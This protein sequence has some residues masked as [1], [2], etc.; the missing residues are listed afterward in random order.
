MTDSIQ[1]LESII[2]NLVKKD[3]A[4]IIHAGHF[5]LLY[6]KVHDKIIPGI[7]PYMKQAGFEEQLC[8]EM[9]LF[10][11]LTWE[12]AVKLLAR[13]EAR[14]KNLLIIVNDW[15]YLKE[16]KERR[17]EFYKDC[18]ALPREFSKILEDEGLAESLL[19]TPA[20]NVRTGVY[21]SEKHMRKKFQ[22][23]VK[24]IGKEINLTEMNCDLEKTG[25]FCGN[26]NCAA[27][28]AQVIGEVAGA[29]NAH[30]HVFVN[31]YPLSCRAFVEEGSR[32]ATDIFQLKHTII[33][34]I[35][36]SNLGIKTIDDVVKGMVLSY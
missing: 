21:F 2:N 20:R 5:L 32:V 8:E 7:Y 1:K 28:I 34:N 15:Q 18:P 33:L 10:P 22:R 4:L 23:T 17:Y 9:G 14:K 13:I 3:S 6:D 25:V 36:V 12:L 27:E 24:K 30:A 31:F 19:L 29:N 26:P 11:L 35:G 16:F